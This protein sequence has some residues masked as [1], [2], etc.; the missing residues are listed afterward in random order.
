MYF[1]LFVFETIAPDLESADTM[2][3]QFIPAPEIFLAGALT[4]LLILL[5][6]PLLSRVNR[7]QDAKN[8]EV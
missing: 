1:N 2:T 6:I 3:T 5:C 8:S 4:C 7:K